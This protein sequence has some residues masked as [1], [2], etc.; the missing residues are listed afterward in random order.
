VVVPGPGLVI[1]VSVIVL[2]CAG[3]IG[4]VDVGGSAVVI[5]VVLRDL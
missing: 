1:A 5:G 4:R 3:G 2:P